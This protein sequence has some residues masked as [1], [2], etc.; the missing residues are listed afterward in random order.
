[1]EIEKA[2]IKIK[3]F[4]E[5]GLTDNLSDL[6]MKF[7]GM[8]GQGAKELC[9]QFD[10]NSELLGCAFEIKKLAAQINVIIHAAGI[11]A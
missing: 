11:L 3:Q 7:K 2:A 4:E 10:I 6:E 9:G 5:G 8:D 1:M